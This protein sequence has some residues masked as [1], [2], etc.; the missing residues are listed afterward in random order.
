MSATS[1]LGLPLI[2]AAQS[3]KHVTHN[4]ALLQLDGVVHLAVASRNVT[5]PPAS[6]NEGD[7][8]LVGAGATG[9]F[10]SQTNAVALWQS[11][12]WVY[13]V[14]KVGWRA[15]VAA[16]N[17]LGVFDGTQWRDPQI[18]I[19]SLQ[20]LTSL[21]IGTSADSTNRF[22]AKSNSMLLTAR[23]SAEGGSGDLRVALNKASSTN[24]GS[25]LLQT[26]YSGRAEFGLTGDDHFRVKVSPDGTAWAS[27]I[28][29]DPV[30]ARVNLPGGFASGC[31]ATS[32][33]AGVVKPGPFVTVAADGT[34]APQLG[35]WT[36]V[37]SAASVDLGAQAS[38]NLVI[39]GTTSIAS[40][41]TTA[42]THGLPYTLRFAGVLTLVNSASLIL[43]GAASIVT[44]AGDIADVVWEGAGVWRVI[45]YQRASGTALMG[46]GGSG[47]SGL[48]GFRNRLVNGDMRISQRGA[49]TIAA[50]APA[51]SA[52]DRF[53]VTAGG[54]AVTTSQASGLSVS[55]SSNALT[56]VGAAGNT[57]LAIGQRLEAANIADLAGQ[58]VTVSGWLFSSVAVT[59]TL[60]VSSPN[61][62]DNFAAVTAM[63]SG[64]PA[65]PALA[66]NV[67]TFFAATFTLPAAA[68]N[69]AQIE[70]GFGATVA[71]VTRQLVNLQLEAGSIATSFERRPIGTE[72][73]FCQR[74]YWISSALAG[75]W[76]IVTTT[77][78]CAFTFPVAM[79]TAPSAILLNGSVSGGSA[80]EPTTAQRVVSAIGAS[81]GTVI[82]TT[83][84]RMDL[85]TVAASASWHWG[86]L[87]S[88]TLGFSA[89][90]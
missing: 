83:G 28:D 66:A 14:P 86:I 2:D 59:P 58:Q 80:L 88:G 53:Y 34:L 72:L 1:L 46:S 22:A 68:A 47:A 25:F 40:F 73:A 87:E 62:R 30:T 49:Q 78:T 69:G 52:C 79:R 41:G 82:T 35:A 3:Q 67:W 50:G 8:Y 55:G 37:A 44:A 36:S 48:T 16:E 85:T 32:V 89:E 54:A 6:P 10:V 63:T 74:Y 9:A 5:V 26:N 20:N 23:T 84:G 4:S 56:V 17:L 45:S 27:A 43:P 76:G 90:L 12:A 51:Y 39:T 77:F 64:I 70:I 18:N 60:A 29:I 31:I 21:G 65:L 11:G 38:L 24:T 13:L 57:Q 61:S 71:G 15:Y 42:T 19:Q 81:N 75:G 33:Q 7:R